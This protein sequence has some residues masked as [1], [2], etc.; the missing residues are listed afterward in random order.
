MRRRC[1]EQTGTALPMVMGVLLLM[2]GIAMLVTQESVNL[3]RTS[4][5]DRN[6][7]SALA[8]AQAGVQAARYRI[9][10]LAPTDPM[11]VTNIAVAPA[12][13]GNCPGFSE[14]LGNGASY[15]YYTT[16]RLTAGGRVCR[17]V[18]RGRPAALHNL[19]GNR[20]RRHAACAGARRRVARNPARQG[21]LRT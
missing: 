6:S 9:A 12:A 21:A 15:T 14:S 4:S 16:P 10:K 17:L 8:A 19:D 5:A 3:A 1:H 7:K 11:C 2:L 18:H 13:D 20:L